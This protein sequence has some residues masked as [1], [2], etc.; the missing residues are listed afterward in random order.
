MSTMAVREG[1]PPGPKPEYLDIGGRRVR[2]LIQ[3]GAGDAVVL[4]H[5]FG[6]SLESWSMNQ[7]ALA[8]SGRTVAAFD[9][10]GHG[11]SYKTLESGSLEE[12]C[13]ATLDYL[14]AVGIERAHFIGHSMG[15][16][17]CLLAADQA[18]QR[19]MSLTLIAPAGLRQRISKDFIQGFMAAEN[20]AQLTPWLRMLFADES[21]VTR[22]LVEDM[23][24]YKRLDGVTEALTKIASSRFGGTSSGGELRD[25]VGRVPT[26]I[27]WGGQDAIIP[28]PAVDALDGGNV[29]LHVL[30]QHGHMVQVEAAGEVNRLIDEF[31]SR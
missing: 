3:R 6:S 11:E 1:E 5:G 15:A 21:H 28:A 20:Q 8:E 19:A 7:A 14:D 18:P 2:H 4:V 16:A 22:Q 27:I 30:P 23:Q 25:V 10:P 13:S 29:E 17:V 24:K 12:L 31:L 9:L 26:L